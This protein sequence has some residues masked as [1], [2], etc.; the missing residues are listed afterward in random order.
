MY[1]HF[2]SRNESEF[3]MLIDGLINN[4]NFKP[5]CWVS[6]IVISCII[7]GFLLFEE[8]LIENL[9]E[10]CLNVML[11]YSAQL[12]DNIFNDLV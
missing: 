1:N 5:V 7:F 12:N 6:N 2:K 10:V 9:N 8:K 11:S 4:Y 3:R